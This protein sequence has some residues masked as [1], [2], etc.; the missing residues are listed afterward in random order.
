M[1]KAIGGVVAMFGVTVALLGAALFLGNV[2]GLMATVPFAGGILVAFGSA[3]I[4]VGR[5]LLEGQ[6]FFV[7]FEKRRT[8]PVLIFAGLLIFVPLEALF[9]WT[10][11]RSV[12]PPL[13][14]GALVLSL[15]V[16]LGTSAGIFAMLRDLLAGNPREALKAGLGIAAVLVL[17]A[18]GLWLLFRAMAPDVFAE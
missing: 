18:G 13:S 6:R 17:V 14:I 9:V 5:T 2:T 4:G 15:A 10:T 11:Y 12:T 8:S 3:L 7:P 1:R 16:L